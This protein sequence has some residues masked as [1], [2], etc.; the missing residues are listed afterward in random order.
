MLFGDDLIDL[1]ASEPIKGLSEACNVVRHY[2]SGVDEWNPADFDV[3]W[4]AYILFQEVKSSDLF[5]FEIEIP[6]VDP[7][8]SLSISCKKLNA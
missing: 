4:E 1:I 5:P 3:L 6:H 2:V 7:T 8:W